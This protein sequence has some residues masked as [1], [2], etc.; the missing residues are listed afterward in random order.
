MP[1]KPKE[2]KEDTDRQKHIRD[3]QRRA[4]KLAGG[5]LSFFESEE[6]SQEL[7]EEPCRPE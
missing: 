3:S 7:P 4:E 2:T 5:E 6:M 1:K